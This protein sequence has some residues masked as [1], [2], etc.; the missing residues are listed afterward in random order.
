MLQVSECYH[1]SIPVSFRQL[2]FVFTIIQLN[3]PFCLVVAQSLTPN[4]ILGIS[5]CHIIYLV[6]PVAMRISHLD[7]SSHQMM[8]KKTTNK[9][10]VKGCGKHVYK[11]VTPLL[12][13]TMYI[14]YILLYIIL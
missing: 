4:Y 6:S 8:I 2:D 12:E 7:T 10:A 11:Q 13:I 9:T 1:S 5:C 14:I 3:P